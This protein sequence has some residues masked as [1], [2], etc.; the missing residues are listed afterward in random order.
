MSSHLTPIFRR[1]LYPL[2]DYPLVTVAKAYSGQIQPISDCCIG[3]HVIIDNHC[4]SILTWPNRQKIDSTL[5]H[6]IVDFVRI[7]DAFIVH[8]D[9]ESGGPIGTLSILLVVMNDW[10]FFPYEGYYA[11]LSH[12]LHVA[13]N[14]LYATLTM[15]GDIVMVSPCYIFTSILLTSWDQA[16]RCYIVNRRSRLVVAVPAVLISAGAGENNVSLYC[17]SSYIPFSLWLCCRLVNF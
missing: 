6:T 17:D 12:P 2:L 16:W 11:Q 3:L 1:F 14:A 7:I 13:K 8:S 10:P 9:P 5:Q 15:V 4:K